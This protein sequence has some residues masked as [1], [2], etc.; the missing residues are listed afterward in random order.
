VLRRERRSAFRTRLCPAPKWRGAGD[1]TAV[2]PI[3]DALTDEVQLP[4]DNIIGAD[5]VET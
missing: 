1:A 5:G 2:S 3:N 4:I